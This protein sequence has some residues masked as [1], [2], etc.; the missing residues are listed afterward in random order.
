MPTRKAFATD[1]LGGHPPSAFLRRF[2]QK[3]PLLVRG[4]VPGFAGLF[5][6]EELFA[7]AGRDDV[8]SRLIV[9]NGSRWTLDH[10]PFRKAHFKTLPATRWT[11][12]VQGVNLHSDA[13]DALLRRFAFAPYA[14]LDD[15]MVSY[16]APGG[17]VGP[18]FDSYDVFLLQGQGHR[19]WQYGRQDDLALKAGLPVKILRNFAPQFDAVLTP[20]DMLY[21]PPSC[22]HDGVAVGPC[23]TY[24]IGFR[25]ASF[26]EF[27]QGFL[28]HLRDHLA[29]TGRYADPGLKSS[30]EPAR[31]GKA[32]QKRVDS[33]LRKIQWDARAT[34]RFLGTYLS[35][36]KQDVVFDRPRPRI[37]PAAFAKAVARRGVAL[38]RRTQWLYDDDTI[39]VNGETAPWPPG[40]RGLLAALANG[41]ALSA[42]Q[43]ASLAAT[44]LAF[45]Y[46]GY[47]HGFLHVS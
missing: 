24:S 16:A 45:L 19:R 25:A 4:A 33:A 7:L 13:A 30:D 12:L 17:G 14:R 26:D 28:D 41:R 15:L 32:M 27:G 21:L 2:W 6:R 11:L 22:A 39:Y 10:G 36:P 46:D 3:E 37:S 34:A 47:S 42:A 8:E 20:G 40:E 44:E 29:L 38:D 9:R 18:H 1:L 43:A 31:I 23:T 35:E 5:T